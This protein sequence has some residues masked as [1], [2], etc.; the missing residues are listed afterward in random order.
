MFDP[1]TITINY[2]ARP[3]SALVRSTSNTQPV[4]IGSLVVGD[5]ARYRLLLVDANGAT[6]SYSGNPVVKV[7]GYI[8]GLGDARLVYS[9]G[10]IATGS[11]FDL[12]FNLSTGSLTNAVGSEDTLS[13]YLQF[14]ATVTGSGAQYSGSSRVIAQIPLTIRNT[15][16]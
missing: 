8:G 15:V 12:F 10:S 13:T 11:Y 1:K 3:E 16:S 2:D 7:E 6:S 4:S 9:S 5:I 14:K